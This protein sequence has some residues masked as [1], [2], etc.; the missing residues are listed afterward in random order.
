MLAHVEVEPVDDVVLLAVEERAV[1]R[2]HLLGIASV[3][4]LPRSHGR[5][6]GD[7]GEA[8]RANRLEPSTQVGLVH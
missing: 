2:V 4:L 8:E 7:P 6:I 5:A 1:A 3:D